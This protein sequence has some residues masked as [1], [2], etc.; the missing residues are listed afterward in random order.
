MLASIEARTTPAVEGDAGPLHSL[1]ILK[2]GLPVFAKNFGQAEHARGEDNQM[3][4]S[5]FLTALTSFLRDMKD[6]GEMKSLVTSSDFRFT[7]YQADS[8]LFVTCTD[9]RMN[10]IMVERF[11]RNIS[12]KFLKAY[13]TNINASNMVNMKHFAG[14][15]SILQREMLSRD[16]RESTARVLPLPAEKPVPRLLMDAREAR[17]VFH[18]GDDLYEH[19][20]KYIDGKTDVDAIAK[21]SS[22]DAARVGAFV[23]HL[24][25]LGIVAV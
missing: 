1:Y 4:V 19:V 6:Y 5:G 18:L 9:G 7:F 13:S 25:K 11:L 23:R 16:L 24:T 15:E 12:M 20:I 14:F 10:E 21:L 3:L 17:Q 8:L 22:M 2:N